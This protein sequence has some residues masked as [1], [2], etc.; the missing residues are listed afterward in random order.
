MIN[1]SPMTERIGKVTT[2]KKGLECIKGTQNEEKIHELINRIKYPIIQENGQRKL[3]P[4]PD[5]MGEVPSRGCEVF[6][7]KIPRD[8]FEDEIFPVFEKIGPIYELRLM[9]D[10]D[11]RNRGFCF[12]MFTKKSH[13]RNAISKLNNY[14]IR[15]GRTLGVCSS[16]DNC[17]LFVGGIPKARK[18]EEILAEIKKVTENV[19]DVIV[20]PSAAD[21]NKNRGFAFV[22]YTTHRAAAMARRKL[23]T[24]RIQ[25]WGH[26]IAVDWAEPEEDVDDDV[27]K[28]VK[29][30]YVR[31]LLID[32]SE[33]I[34]RNHFQQFGKVERV[35]K[36]RDYAFIHFVERE[37]AEVAMD[38]GEQQNVDG[39]TVEISFAKPIDKNNHNQ[40]AKVGARALAALQHGVDPVG[41]QQ[42][43]VYPAMG[44]VPV[45]ISTD[46]SQKS[47]YPTKGTQGHK[48]RSRA[49]AR[50]SYLGYSAGKATYGRYFTKNTQENDQKSESSIGGLNPIETLDDICIRSQWGKPQYQ[51]IQSPTTKD[52]KQ[53]YLYRIL[54]LP[55]GVT[56]QSPKLSNTDQEAKT[57]AAEA[58]LIQLGFATDPTAQITAAPSPISLSPPSAFGATAAGGANGGM[59]HFNQNARQQPLQQQQ[60]F[61]YVQIPGQGM[62]AVP[63]SIDPTTMQPLQLVYQ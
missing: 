12:V 18:K 33:D 19:E 2:I 31:N 57:A 30:L 52:G 25:L 58:A 34:L 55:L 1:Q 29:V 63:V 28:E 46:P 50:S 45:I 53:T 24:G 60:M 39:A 54:I 47:V 5:H 49:G 41:Q 59:V 6:V 14:E 26:P 44:G 37:G 36:I 27:M 32:T 21:K 23:V 15:K 38:A 16:V 56:I 40:L 61:Q 4:M 42:F 8:L 48:G 3:G 20:Y 7:G 22:E 9:M 17:R 35:K 13:A 62:M 43:L 10:F 11:G 51:L